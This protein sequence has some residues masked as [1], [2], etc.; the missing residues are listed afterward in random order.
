MISERNSRILWGITAF[1]A[2]ILLAVTITFAVQANA[3]DAEGGQRV[4]AYLQSA[5][6]FVIILAE[7]EYRSTVASIQTDETPIIVTEY[8]RRDGEDWYQIDINEMESGWV[9]GR[10]VSLERP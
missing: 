7:P 8:L 3:Q 9:Q 1:V 5:Q 10:Y 4:R 6:P 2:L